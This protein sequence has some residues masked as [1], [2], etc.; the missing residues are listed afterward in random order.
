MHYLKYAHYQALVNV[1]SI[2]NSLGIF[3]TRKNAQITFVALFVI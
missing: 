1:K 2:G 3:L